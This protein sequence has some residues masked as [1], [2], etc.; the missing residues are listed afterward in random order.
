MPRNFRSFGISLAAAV[1]LFG[2]TGCARKPAPADLVLL[3]GDVATMNPAMPAA[4][5]VVIT[6]NKIT[7][8]C[9]SDR[10]A[11]RY[12]GPKTR[13]FDLLGIFVLPGLIDGHVHF[14]AAGVML[15]GPNLLGVSD[16][17]GLRREVQRVVDLLDDGEWITDGLWGSDGPA[18][19][20]VAGGE[21][22]DKPASWRPTRS[23]IDDLTPNH[24]CFLSRIDGREWLAN[25]A[26]LA[27]AGLDKQ[28][29][30]GLD[31]APDGKPTGII[32]PATPAFDRM[33]KAVKQKSE[34]RL[35]D[36]SRAALFALREAGVT[37]IHDVATPEQTKRFIEL[38]KNGELSCRVWLQPDL[39]RG[40]EL[41]AQGFAQGSHPATKEKS[42]RL[43]Y[44]V[45]QG[46]AGGNGGGQAARPSLG[47]DWPGT[48]AMLFQ[49]HPKDLIYAA[50]TGIAFK[51]T[52]ESGWRPEPKI[53]V[54]EALRAV[55]IDN[56]RAAFE[57]SVRGSLEAGK[58]A[59]VAV[60]DRNL[61]KIAASDILNA[62]VTHT[63]VDG[64]IV[65]RRRIDPP[66]K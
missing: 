47:S 49:V 25:S 6:G 44:G 66:K 56:A 64:K 35:I 36:E 1:A 60:F 22:K 2:L 13:V 4:R 20:G 31:I 51:G 50:V 63:I 8:V 43:R 52:P 54:E 29:L 28:R 5:A 39:T 33:K 15:A 42:S 65:Y 12:V 7:A 34:I 3:N 23:M 38:E 61:I 59:D 19:P 58:L 55:T 32:F 16:A 57:E 41:T 9:A 18:A 45:L 14:E 10:Q 53:P 21:A 17:A 46:P 62:R 26:A 30:P 11:R 27:E 24:P 37:E 40:A 48:G